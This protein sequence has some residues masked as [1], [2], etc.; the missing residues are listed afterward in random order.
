MFKFRL[1]LN[2]FFVYSFLLFIIIFLGLITNFYL[3]ERHNERRENREYLQTLAKIKSSEIKQWFN[4]RFSDA[5]YL[6]SNFY[7]KEKLPGFTSSPT[8]ADSLKI[9]RVVETMFKNHDYKNIFI[10]NSDRKCILCMNP[11]VDNF[12]IDSVNS[13]LKDGNIKFSNF[14]RNPSGFKIDLDIYIPILSKGKPASVIILKIDP[15]KI[16][17]PTVKNWLI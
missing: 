4:E 3:D 2:R 17:F 5:A 1:K 15:Y 14:Y 12:I 6:Y 11:D 16:I 8:K 9:A 10:L 13:A 7:I